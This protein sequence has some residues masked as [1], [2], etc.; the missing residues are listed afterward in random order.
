VKPAHV[1]GFSLVE[2]MV[3]IGMV[4]ILAALAV[5]A[6]NELVRTSR[7]RGASMELQSAFVRARSEAIMRNTDVELVPRDADWRNGWTL[8]VAGGGPVIEER[9][10]LGEVS[11][12]PA[13]APAVR[14]R[15]NGRV[16]AGSQSIVISGTGGAQVHAR[17][18]TLGPGG[19]AKVAV[20]VDFDTSDGCS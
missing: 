19:R 1:H 12:Q 9:E 11:I 14:Y 17:C 20:D 15:L 4:A 18:I 3:V 10:V 16:A 7:V 13:P 2:L 8:Q 6:M 5:P